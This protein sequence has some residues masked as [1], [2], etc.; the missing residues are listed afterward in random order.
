MQ[1]QRAVSGGTP[2]GGTRTDTHSHPERPPPGGSGGNHRRGRGGRAGEREP[3]GHRVRV[4]FAS[5]TLGGT[6][7]SHYS[8]SRSQMTEKRLHGGWRLLS[9][10]TWSLLKP[11]RFRERLDFSFAVSARTVVGQQ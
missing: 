3:K 6:G 9:V 1:T 7:R 2:H 11:S 5:A 10:T 4:P 8:S